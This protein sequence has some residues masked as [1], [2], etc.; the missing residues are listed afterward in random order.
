MPIL[1]RSHAGFS[2]EPEDRTHEGTFLAFIY[3]FSQ[4]EP[5]VWVMLFLNIEITHFSVGEVRTPIP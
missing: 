4:I 2:S 5:L 3:L 1:R